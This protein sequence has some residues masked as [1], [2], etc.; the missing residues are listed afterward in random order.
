MYD[1]EAVHKLLDRSQESEIVEDQ[2]K[3]FGLNEYLSK[4]TFYI[5][6]KLD[7]LRVNIAHYTSSIKQ[8]RNIFLYIFTSDDA[9]GIINILL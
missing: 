4:E 7:C 1:D 5:R 3:E 2:E 6:I 9:L 8:L